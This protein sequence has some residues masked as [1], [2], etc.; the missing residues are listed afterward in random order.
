MRVAHTMPTTHLWILWQSLPN[1]NATWI[2]SPCCIRTD[3]YELMNHSA[4]PMDR[5][6][7]YNT[8]T[9]YIFRGHQN[10]RQ[11]P[12]RQRRPDESMW[13]TRVDSRFNSSSRAAFSFGV[14]V[15]G[16]ALTMMRLTV[17]IGSHGTH[18]TKNV[19]QMKK[20]GRK[21]CAGA[22]IRWPTQPPFR[23]DA[24]A[25]YL[26]GAF[27]IFS[28]N[29]CLKRKWTPCPCRHAWDSLLR[30]TIHNFLGYRGPRCTR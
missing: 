24:L 2:A 4:W 29:I 18:K 28:R 11:K 14:V 10:V 6:S 5:C 20:N 12:N 23:I 16:I 30:N 9:I 21:L 22:P 15:V 26:R 27:I 13:T 19:P 3:C 17:V 25:R 8:F 7:T 1:A